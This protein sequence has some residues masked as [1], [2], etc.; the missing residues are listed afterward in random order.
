MAKKTDSQP[1]LMLERTYNVP[2]RKEYQKAPMYKRAKKAGYAL[3]EFLEK[4]M[5]SD[6]I[7]IGRH[8]NMKVWENGIK[9][10]PHHVN[11]L[12][13]KYEDGSVDAE[14]VD[15]PAE[16]VV[17]PKKKGKTKPVEKAPVDAKAEKPVKETPIKA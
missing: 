3:R 8:L 11:V 13:K 6:T 17:E 1:K 7:R 14:L 12:V 10:P 4:H 5:K 15:A 9:N 2:L 16:K